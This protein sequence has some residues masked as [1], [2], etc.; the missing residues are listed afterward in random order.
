MDSDKKLKNAFAW[1]PELGWRLLRRSKSYKQAVSEFLDAAHNANDEQSVQ[2]YHFLSV[3]EG[4]IYPKRPKR[5][6]KED[7]IRVTSARPDRLGVN[8]SGWKEKRLSYLKYSNFSL[9]IGCLT[10]GRG[11]Y[12]EPIPTGIR[13]DFSTKHY[14]EFNKWF[15][16]ILKFPINPK[17]RQP[18]VTRLNTVWAYRPVFSSPVIYSLLATDTG[19]SPENRSILRPSE[20]S[21]ISFHMLA[22][23]SNF[24]L[25]TILREIREYLEGHL[26]KGR[27]TGEKLKP[28]WNELK[29]L[30]AVVE[31]IDNLHANGRPWGFEKIGKHCVPDMYGSD[32]D[33]KIRRQIDWA[34]KR[35]N[36]IEKVLMPLFERSKPN[37]KTRGY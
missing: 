26:D 24:D 8:R 36:Y 18:D 13:V 16:D 19:I 31:V 17:T 9:D 14:Q 15:G 12:E 29:D 34:R 23:N 5:I 35:K 2:A 6:K 30:L 22:I 21:K 32:N 28:R 33:K 10:A 11:K 1:N 3:P 20:H 27:L 37:H 4:E 7:L 25:N